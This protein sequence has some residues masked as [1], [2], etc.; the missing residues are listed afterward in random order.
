MELDPKLNVPAAKTDPR[1]RR[2]HLIGVGGVAMTA[3]A[4][5]LKDVGFSVS[6][7]DEDVYPPM[8]DILENL[9]IPVTKG[10]GPDTLPPN[11]TSVVGNVVTRKFP[12]V[13]TL[14]KSAGP[15]L[16]M[17]QTLG[18]LFLNKTKNIVVAGCHGKTT[19]TN[20]IA[21]ILH[22]LGFNPGYLIGG[23]SLDL[24]KSYKVASKE[25]FVIEGDEYDSAFFQKV[26]KFLFYRP[27]IVVLTGVEFDHADI[28]PDLSAVVNAYESLVKLIPPHGLLI[29][30][31][32]DPLVKSI[33]VKCQAKV[34]FYGQ[35]RASDWRMMKYYAGESMTFELKGPDGI[36]TPIEWSQVGKHNALNATAAMAA[37][38]RAGAN[39]K[40]LPVVMAQIKGV[41]RRQENLGTYAGVKII[42]D[43]AHHPTAVNKTLLAIKETTN[44]RLVVA[45]EPRSA[46]SRTAIFQEEYAKAF[47]AAKV[48]FIGAVNRPD[49]APLDSRLDPVALVK[50]INQNG[51]LAFYEPDPDKLV[52]AILA[53]VKPLETLVLM[54][55]GDFNGLADKL[56]T[57]LRPKDPTLDLAR[58]LLPIMKRPDLLKLALTHPSSSFKGETTNQRLEFLGDS[59]LGLI[60]SEMLY[61][62]DESFNEGELSQ[63][64]A[65]LV[66]QK[67]LSDIARKVGLG[68]YLLLG[69]GE[70]SAF[71]REK[72]SI[73]ADAME[74]VIGAHYLSEGFES[75]KALVERLWSPLRAE[76]LM[77]DTAIKDYKSTLQEIT[78]KRGL[79]VPVYTL[80][81]FV[82]PDNERIFTMGLKIQGELRAE[83]SGRSKKEAS[84]AAAKKLIDELTKHGM[85]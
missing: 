21:T 44:N 81:K 5:L 35:S 20:L 76:L 27:L 59:V 52:A 1:S 36:I 46:T 82:G 48:V 66:N 15:Y 55:N 25:Y 58:T 42:D 54:S 23:Q 62:Q 83:A 33:A 79:G 10:Y 7:Q 4:G 39:P 64:R 68:C 34:D 11:V 45:F 73:L 26:P 6:G 3:L 24:P 22:N 63:M 72:D 37:A 56:L 16:S 19:T 40:D 80:L 18:E 43:F 9:K 69:P 47:K 41:K 61:N 13:E 67:P 51:T 84:Q 53:E 60:V 32:D 14:A 75:T 8:S 65:V 70:E 30:N 71:G 74:A 29:A 31:G 38:I 50:A 28:Y 57:A 49:K 2:F 12:V 17:P 77:E 78:Q 85:T